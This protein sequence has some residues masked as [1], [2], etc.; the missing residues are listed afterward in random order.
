MQKTRSGKKPNSHASVKR[1]VLR[2]F[3]VI[4]PQ[5]PIQ[6]ASS[7]LDSADRIAR[8]DR[9]VAHSRHELQPSLKLDF[10]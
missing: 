2:R 9:L 10:F 4:L 8:S 5:A 3:Q 6:G 7:L 1:S